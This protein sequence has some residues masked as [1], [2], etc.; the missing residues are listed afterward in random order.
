M[1]AQAIATLLLVA[2]PDSAPLPKPPRALAGA[3]TRCT[4]ALVAK[5]GEGE[6][7]RAARGARQAAAFWRTTDGGAK[8]FEDL[9]VA[10]FR[11]QGPELDAT[12]ARLEAAFEALDGHGLEIYRELSRWAQL[13]V[14][15]MQP[16][17]ALLAAHDPA[18]HLVDDLFDGKVAFA[19][20]L[21]FPL[22][23]LDERLAQGAGWTRR[24]WADFEIALGA[25]TCK[26]FPIH[27]DQVGSGYRGIAARFGSWGR[28]MPV[29]HAP[30]TVNVRLFD[31]S[32]TPDMH[33]PFA[34][35]PPRRV[36][37]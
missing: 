10:Q 30:L 1:F 9:C 37:D 31:N 34:R 11:P 24:Q 29:L 5:H 15:P 3:V 35:Q 33:M 25:Q 23:T 28:W 2:T 16:V 6:R 32:G 26:R 4:G 22:T 12:F 13:D 17:D 20:L 18:A 7:A 19:A 21:N 36:A 14:G 8:A 27:M